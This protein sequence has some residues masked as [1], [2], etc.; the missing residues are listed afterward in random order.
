VSAR[1]IAPVSRVNLASRL[2]RRSRPDHRLARH[3]AL[4][5]CPVTVIW[6]PFIL[7]GGCNSNSP[8]ILHAKVCQVQIL[9]FRER[10]GE[11]RWGTKCKNSTFRRAAKGLKLFIIVYFLSLWMNVDQVFGGSRASKCEGPLGIV[12]H[13]FFK[14][15]NLVFSTF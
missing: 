4:S 9:N 3:R 8:N 2:P 1:H 12:F 6:R 5:R 11:R 10:A 13:K 14:G 15:K 7:T